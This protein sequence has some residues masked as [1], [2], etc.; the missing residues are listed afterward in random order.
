MWV[1]AVWS[2]TGVWVLMCIDKV[3][4]DEVDLTFVEADWAVCWDELL[5]AELLTSLLDGDGHML[6]WCRPWQL[7]QFCDE[8]QSFPKCPLFKQMKHRPDRN[9]H[10]FR[11]SIVDT[12][13][14][15]WDVWGLLQKQHRADTELSINSAVAV[16]CSLFVLL[17]VVTLAS[18]VVL[19]LASIFSLLF[20]ASHQ[21]SNCLPSLHDSLSRLSLAESFSLEQVLIS[22]HKP[23]SLHRVMTRNEHGI[24]FC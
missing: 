22:S 19:S 24:Q 13:L 17:A 23:Q 2:N 11:C 8:R 9:R 12:V 4:C 18:R 6:T 15:S 14:H 10:C 7:T 21:N 5:L 1:T 20:S 16:A 3:A